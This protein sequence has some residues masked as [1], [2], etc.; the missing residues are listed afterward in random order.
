[1]LL[2]VFFMFVLDG[3]EMVIDFDGWMGFFYTLLGL[4]VEV[5]P[6]L[7]FE[8]ASHLFF[9]YF[10]FFNMILVVSNFGLIF[11]NELLN[12]KAFSF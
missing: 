5:V 11:F 7:F 4:I 2:L 9:D 8:F 10:I 12:L 1:M 3:L 6:E